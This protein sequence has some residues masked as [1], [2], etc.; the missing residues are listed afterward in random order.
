[1]CLASRGL[2]WH[3]D[4]MEGASNVLL[5]LPFYKGALQRFARRSGA[6]KKGSTRDRLDRDAHARAIIFIK[7]SIHDSIQL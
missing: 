3:I 7:W 5:G 4:E 6:S 2:T 1:M